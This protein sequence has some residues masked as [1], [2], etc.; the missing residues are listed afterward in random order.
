MKQAG[1]HSRLVC[2]D[3]G[4]PWAIFLAGDSCAEHEQ[5][6]NMLLNALNID[7]D[8]TMVSG[9]SMTAPVN[10]SG[11][12]CTLTNTYYSDDKKPVKQKENVHYLAL[13]NIDIEK[14]ANAKFRTNRYRL[15]K[16]ITGAWDQGR[17]KIAAWDEESKKFLKA[18]KNAAQAADLTVWTGNTPRELANPFSRVGLIIA[19]TS[20]MPSK[21]REAIDEGDLETARLN[22]AVEKTGIVSRIQDA[23]KDL[24]SWTGG[25][26][27]FALSPRWADTFGTIKRDGAEISLTSEHPVVFYLNPA[28][29]KKFNYG[30]FTVEELDQWLEGKGPVIKDAPE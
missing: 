14:P 23:R 4:L 13:Y 1:H 30:W 11:R 20:R 8:G 17:F 24:C 2:T 10:F 22:A 9:R 25:P 18:V 7:P 27:Y 16:N 3:D 19:I 29:Q 26:P 21:A 6:I 12:T 5:G 28:Q 15:D